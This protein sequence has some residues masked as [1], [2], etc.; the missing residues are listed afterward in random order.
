MIPGPSGHHENHS[1]PMKPIP[2]HAAGV[3]PAV[4]LLLALSASAQAGGL[5]T[6]RITL[7]KYLDLARLSRYSIQRL[8]RARPASVR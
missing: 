4:L 2:R 3:L 1:M 5:E 6:R 8:C 7:A